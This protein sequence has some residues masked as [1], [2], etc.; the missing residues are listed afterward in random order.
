[1]PKNAIISQKPCRLVK[2]LSCLCVCVQWDRMGCTGNICL[3]QGMDKEICHLYPEELCLFVGWFGVEWSIIGGNK[4]AREISMKH[5][6]DFC[7]KKLTS[8][9]V[10]RG[11]IQTSLASGKH[12]QSHN[13]SALHQPCGSVTTSGKSQPH[14][15]MDPTNT[16]KSKSVLQIY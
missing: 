3:S 1:M 6:F 11:F 7:L 14:K 12:P 9:N 16:C 13:I 2:S 10:S 4:I 5:L 15:H 8:L